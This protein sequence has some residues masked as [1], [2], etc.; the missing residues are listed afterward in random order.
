[1]DLVLLL[2]IIGELVLVFPDRKALI[3][4][5]ESKEDQTYGLA[6]EVGSQGMEYY[7]WSGSCYS[8]FI[9]PV[10]TALIAFGLRMIF[11]KLHTELLKPLLV[12]ILLGVYL[13][14]LLGLLGY[15]LST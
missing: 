8:V 13:S 12:L 9:I 15:I 10:N 6:P 1:L 7:M 2:I 3:V 11:C 4:S 14:T 5:G